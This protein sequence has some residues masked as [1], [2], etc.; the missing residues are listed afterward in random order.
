[1]VRS[2][3][4]AFTTHDYNDRHHVIAVLWT[5]PTEKLFAGMLVFIL[6]AAILWGTLPMWRHQI[7]A[8]SEAQA[9]LAILRQ[10][11]AILRQ[12]AANMRQALKEVEPA[13]AARTE[14]LMWPTFLQQLAFGDE[15]NQPI[16]EERGQM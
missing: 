15:F 7:T 13:S 3:G 10:E 2:S 14:G 11:L 12:D 8:R 9:E 16:A 5:E 4:D 1:M 6:L